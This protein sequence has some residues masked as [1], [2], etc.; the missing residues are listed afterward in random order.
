[1]TQTRPRPDPDPG[2]VADLAAII[3]NSD[4]ADATRLAEVIEYHGWQR[5]PL[6]A[7]LLATGSRDPIRLAEAVIR[8][9]FYR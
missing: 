2:P 9:G 7:V 1:M 5:P 3:A 6:W 8:A 4:T